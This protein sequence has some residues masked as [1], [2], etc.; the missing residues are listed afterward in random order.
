MKVSELGEFKLIGRIAKLIEETS[1][2]DSLSRQNLILG[3]GDDAAVW[4]CQGALQLTT[5]DCM[6]QD[7]HFNLAYTDWEELGHKSIAVNLSDI[8]AM[9]GDPKYATVSLSLPGETDVEDVISLYKGMISIC[10]RYGVMIIGGNV[11]AAD[12]III[13][14]TLQGFCKTKDFFTRSSAK[15]GDLIALTG[16]TGLSAA[17]MKMLAGK[18][19]ID[20]D[21]A[22]M[23]KKAHLRPEPK[24]NEA[25]G[26]LNMGIKTAIDLS[27][28]VMSDLKH[29]CDASGVS[30]T[31]QQDLVQIHPALKKYFPQEAEQLA[32]SGGEDYELLFTGNP[33]TIQ[34]IKAK[35]AAPVNIIGE[36]GRGPIGK[37]TVFDRTGKNVSVQTPGWEHFK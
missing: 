25:R 23:L 30:A 20:A 36:I 35:A 33:A 28:G 4:K 27:D 9:G 6:I 1:H 24:L 3:I 18:M 34:K 16:F 12:K 29:I 11:S 5:T 2:I 14:V 26:L 19:N 10:N 31:I 13:N 32:L 17:G 7:V 21:T 15:P 37:I 8:A 22:A